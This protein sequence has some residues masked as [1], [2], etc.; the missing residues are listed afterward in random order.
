MS[1]ATSTTNGK[2]VSGPV[3]S[4]DKQQATLGQQ[5]LK[6]VYED[7]NTQHILAAAPSAKLEIFQDYLD[8]LEDPSKGSKLSTL[9]Q[10]ALGF[11]ADTATA[12]KFKQLLAAKRTQIAKKR[13]GKYTINNANPNDKLLDIRNYHNFRSSTDEFQATTATTNGLLGFIPGNTPS[14]SYFMSAKDFLFSE[15]LDMYAKEF[16]YD[17]NAGI[18]P[19]I[20]NEYQPDVTKYFSKIAADLLQTNPKVSKALS[21]LDGSIMQVLGSNVSNAMQEICSYNPAVLYSAVKSG[22]TENLDPYTQITKMFNNRSM[23]KFI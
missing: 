7:K 16:E 13:Y 2:D 4:Q 3:Q 19:I 5:Y 10:S 21:F 1:T 23:V 8:F 18:Q 14:K 22:I 17:Y 6:K 9:Q 12:N 11:S 15:S 20:L